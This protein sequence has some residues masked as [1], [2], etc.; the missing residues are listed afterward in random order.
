MYSDKR[1]AQKKYWRV[2]EQK[3]F[4][5][6]LLFGSA[7]ILIGMKIFRHKTKHFKFIYG[8]PLILAAQLY[9]LYKLIIYFY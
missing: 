2:P 9:I 8:I 5:L 1:K 6:A 7:G 3:L 4:I